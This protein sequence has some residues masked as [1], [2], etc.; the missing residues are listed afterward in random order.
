MNALQNIKIKKSILFLGFVLLTFQSFANHNFK[1]CSNHEPDSFEFFFCDLCG[2]STSSGSF[3]LGTLNNASFVGVRYIYQTFES[4][5]GIFSNSPTSEENFHTYQLWGRLPINENLYVSAILPY[6]DL[7]R[8]YTDREENIN[9][10][11]D[12]TIM[13]WYKFKFYK[14][15]DEEKAK[16]Y[17]NV[18]R[19]PSGHSLEIG[20]GAK[21][22]TGK[23]E[24]VLTDR[25]N[26][27]F[28]LG[29]GSL[30]GILGLAHSYGS[31][32]FGVNTSLTY[33]FKNE[34]K[35]EYKFGN[36]FSYASN[37]FYAISKE[38]YM[39]LPFVGL[40]GNIY[41][42]IEQ[43]QEE[44]PKTDGNVFN[45]TFGAEI[46]TKDF[47]IGANYTLPISHNLFGGNVTPKQSLSI[48]LNF[49]LNN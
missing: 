24:Q 33:Y 17:T 22:P 13:S 19:E 9:G 44:I 21:L 23:F 27:G 36:Q 47:I 38:K 42:K 18:Q 30:D 31:D 41:D 49:N 29:T 12:A 6:Q 48:Y 34:N 25:V 35:N 10:F 39:L 32:K 2:C 11:G 40:S 20:L 1:N 45:G 26:P 3:G 43:Y 14:K 5:D 4:K 8:T 28:Q 16:L 15:V 37:F 46:T 7:K